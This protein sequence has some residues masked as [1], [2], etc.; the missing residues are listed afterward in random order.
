MRK[1]HKR[2]HRSCGLCK[3]H[4]PKLTNRWKP[5]DDESIRRTEKQISQKDFSD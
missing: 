5:K 3:P 4:K 2:K 1:S